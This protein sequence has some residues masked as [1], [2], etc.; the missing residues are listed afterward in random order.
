VNLLWFS[1]A[2]SAPI[3][4]TILAPFGERLATIFEECE[5][6]LGRLAVIVSR[7]ASIAQPGIELARQFCRDQFL[8]GPLNRPEGF[9]LHAHKTFQL[10]PD[11]TVNSWIRIR[12]AKGGSP[13]YSYVTVQQDI[14]TLATEL[15]TRQFGRAQIAATFQAVSREVDAILGMYFPSEE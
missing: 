14:N 12:T 4:G 7:Q 2:G 9:E 5:E 11:L 6:Q 13:E 3:L 8:E 15:Q 10:M 1:R